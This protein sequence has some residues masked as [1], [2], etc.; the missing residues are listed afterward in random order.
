MKKISIFL[1][2]ILIFS[3]FFVQAQWKQLSNF[4][5]NNR[6]GAVGFGFNNNGFV[7]CGYDNFTY[8]K[9]FF[10]Y[11][12][13]GTGTSPCTLERASNARWGE[14][15]RLVGGRG[16]GNVPS[17]NAT[18]TSLCKSRNRLEPWR[19]VGPCGNTPATCHDDRSSSCRQG[20]GATR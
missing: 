9:G 3:T 4:A 5:G 11:V 16:D 17:K 1:F 6:S 19:V 8:K 14:C 2:S 7:G 15:R 13:A 10:S 12:A 18:R 20:Q